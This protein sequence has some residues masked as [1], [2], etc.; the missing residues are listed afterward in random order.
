MVSR[1][2][3]L[4]KLEYTRKTEMGVPSPS[5]GR[6]FGALKIVLSLQNE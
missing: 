3:L 5:S 1:L 6:S 2:D 4:E